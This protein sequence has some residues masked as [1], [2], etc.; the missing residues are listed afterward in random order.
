MPKTKKAQNPRTGGDGV[1][2]RRRGG[3][4]PINDCGKG[5]KLTKYGN[6]TPRHK[7]PKIHTT[8]NPGSSRLQK[9]IY[10]INGNFHKNFRLIFF[11][12]KYTR[13]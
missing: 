8:S 9:Y 11:F 6:L 3:V 10:Y 7:I 13:I 4:D 2:G 5:P 1:D 12:L